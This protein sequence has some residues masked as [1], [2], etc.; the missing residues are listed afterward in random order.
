M[1]GLKIKFFKIIFTG[2][3]RKLSIYFEKSQQYSNDDVNYNRIVILWVCKYIITIRIN[4][5]V[6]CYYHRMT[7]A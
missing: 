7:C 3:F 2:C 1:Y 4:V 6:R 5:I